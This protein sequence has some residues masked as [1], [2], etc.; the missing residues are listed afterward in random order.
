MPWCGAERGDSCANLRE[1]PA[2]SIA[3][4]E[5]LESRVLL[6][7]TPSPFS[8]VISFT[9]QLNGG[10]THPNSLVMD[11]AGDIFGTTLTGGSHN[12]GTIFEIA[13][14]TTAV[15]T[16]ASFPGGDGGFSPAGDLVLEGGNLF[17]T[18]ANGGTFVR[19][20]LFELNLTT[21]ALTTLA[22]FG[23]ANGGAHPTTGIVSDGHGDFFGTTFGGQKQGATIFEYSAGT[24]ALQTL[25]TLP[26]GVRIDTGVATDAATGHVEIANALTTNGV[27]TGTIFATT[28]N[29]GG[30]VRG[31]IFSYAL[32]VGAAAVHT[33]ASFD[34][35]NGSG[36][37]G[38]LLYVTNADAAGDAG[39][40]GMTSGGG[41]RSDGLLFDAP[42]TV[43]AGVFSATLTSLGS[44]NGTAGARPLGN[45]LLV[46]PANA[47]TGSL[48]GNTLYGTTAVGGGNGNGAVYKIANAQPVAIGAVIPT[49]TQ[50]AFNKQTGQNPSGGLVIGADGTLYGT[51][52]QQGQFLAGTLFVLPQTA[53]V[54]SG[55]H[56]VLR[57]SP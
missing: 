49:F 26:L 48:F 52:S 25:V 8:R 11:S 22:S 56:L 24:G 5:L 33:L 2:R 41:A 47:P 42:L 12:Y 51:T 55:E 34:G 45:L 4:L 54:A 40:V 20:T 32:G 19:G 35:T 6:A 39:L 38:T 14:G 53:P 7:A 1:K 46:N 13:A 29:D 10:G 17:G 37:I 27:T 57:R 28:T 30:S 3:G 36:P 44:F 18:T 43:S 9:G 21:H 15:T 31:T 16:L 23:A 50:L